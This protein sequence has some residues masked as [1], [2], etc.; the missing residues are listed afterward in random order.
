MVAFTTV[1]S[2]LA[3]VAATVPAAA[4][5]L[6][7]SPS[8]TRPNALHS[9]WYHAKDHP[10]HDLFRHHEKRADPSPSVGSDAWSAQYPQSTPAASSIPQSWID[11]LNTAVSAGK[12]PDIPVPTLGNNP[13]PVY[14]GDVNANRNNATVCAATDRE[15]RIPGDIWDAPEG[16]IGIGFDD[17]PTEASPKLYNFLQGQN[18]RSTHYMIGVNVLNNWQ[19]FLMAYNMGI[20]DIAVHTYTHPY[21]TTQTN[22]ELLGQFGWTIQIIHDST[23]GKVPRFWRPPYGDIDTR[24]SAIAREVFGLTAIMWNQDTED[25]SIGS[26]GGTT[27]AKVE[28]NMQT[29]LSGPKSPGL[30]ILEHEL[31]NNTIQCFM[32]A[33]PLVAQNGWKPV[34]QAE[35]DTSVSVYQDG[36]ESDTPFNSLIANT[37]STSSSEASSTSSSSG[38]SALRGTDSAAQVKAS[39]SASPGGR[40][41][42]TAIGLLVAG[43]LALV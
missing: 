34:S 39:S 3:A 2:L 40:P 13:S 21:M 30:I 25:W 20:N 27:V 42:L 29:W 9:R 18:Q 15:C 11:A 12:I 16:V 10:V 36:G 19:E 43:A 41:S 37:A 26:P 23:G 14:P 33:W 31:T 32:N 1:V 8:H 24:V 4:A 38:G 35:L 5:R 7:P 6:G 28:Q 17:G 22:M